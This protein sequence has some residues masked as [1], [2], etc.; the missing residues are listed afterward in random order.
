MGLAHSPR[1]VTDG[2]VLCLDAANTKSYGGSGTTWTDL[3]GNGNDG[4]LVNGVGYSGDN[5]GSLVFDGVND[6]VSIP[7]FTLNRTSGAAISGWIKIS[8]F[9]TSSDV[10]S[11]V[12]VRS[13]SI[14]TS[15]LIAFYSG[16]YAYETNTN[17]NPVEM[18]G[19][20]TPEISDSSI[21]A[22]TYFCFSL[23]FD[24]NTGYSYVNGVLSSSK[25]L[26]NNMQ[27]NQIGNAAGPTNYPDRMKGNIAQVSIYNKA[28][29]AAE[30]AQNFN[31]LRGR[32]GI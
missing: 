28:L 14:T 27:I 6:Y 8:D 24:N 20:S 23:V 13:S 29:S 7:S 3:S 5:L 19:D 32:Y 16:G 25:S 2:L 22:N 17:S 15:R 18:A 30:V 11:R 21:V 1:I 31:A 26:S 12:F 10:P 9:S 4:T